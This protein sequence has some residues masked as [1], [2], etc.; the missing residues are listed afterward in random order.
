VDKA[1]VMFLVPSENGKE[2]FKGTALGLRL[3]GLQTRGIS[4]LK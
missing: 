2:N 3:S 4:Q 1:N